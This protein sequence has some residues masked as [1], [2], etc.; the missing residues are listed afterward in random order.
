MRICNCIALCGSAFFF[1]VVGFIP[2]DWPFLAVVCMTL[3]YSAVATNCGG[4]YKCGT[5][6]AR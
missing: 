5:L 6:I 4:F 3:N 2:D 1:A